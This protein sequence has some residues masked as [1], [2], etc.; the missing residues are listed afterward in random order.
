MPHLRSLPIKNHLA[1]QW[2]QALRICSSFSLLWW[3]TKF[4]KF[5]LLH[6]LLKLN[7]CNLFL[8]Q[9]SLWKIISQHLCHTT[10]VVGINVAC[11]PSPSPSLVS[12]LGLQLLTVWI[13]G[14]GWRKEEIE[15]LEACISVHSGNLVPSSLCP[16]Q[17][18]MSSSL[19]QPSSFFSLEAS[20]L[21]RSVL[22]GNVF[23]LV[24]FFF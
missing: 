18:E 15:S 9:K 21:A 3:I 5:P 2:M 8:V 16:G 19:C 20:Q 7:G 24:R 4:P 6:F 17:H 23:C 12:G 11:V 10:V 22:L 1:A 13:R 14:T